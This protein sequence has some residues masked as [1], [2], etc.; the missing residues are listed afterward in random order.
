M[1]MPVRMTPLVLAT[2]G[3]LLPVRAADFTLAYQMDA[4]RGKVPRMETLRR[5]ADVV[6]SLGYRQL[7]MYFKGSFAYAGHEEVWKD[8]AHFTPAE[9]REL[10]DY[11]ASKGLELVP[12]QSTFSHLEPWLALPRYRPLAEAPEAGVTNR[13]KQV[14]TAPMALCPGDPRSMPLLEDIL[15]QLYPCFRTRL[16]NVGCDEMIELDDG[17]RRS[18]D[19]VARDGVGQVY[20]DF[21]MRLH[22]SVVRNGHVMMFWSDIVRDFPEQVARIP[23]DAIAL[24]WG[25]EADSPFERTTADLEKAP[26]RFYVCPGTSS[27]RSL[28]G[29]H[30]NMRANV[31]AAW[32]SGRRHGA[33][34]LLLTDWGDNGHCQPWIV[35]LPALVYAAAKAQGRTP[36]DAEIAEK[37]DGLCGAKVGAALI[38]LGNAYLRSNASRRKNVTEL[39][40]ACLDGRKYRPGRGVTKADLEASLAECRAAQKL[41]DLTGAPAWVR[42]DMAVVDLLVDVLACRIAG[43]H[44]G[45]TERFAGR[46]RELWNRQYKAEGAEASLANICGN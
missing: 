14:T 10:D 8:V 25:Y 35:S 42:D 19:A 34:G 17:G 33:S 5:M 12:Y 41:I 29:R 44:D 45:L 11:C 22:D 6:S 15:G 7:Q 21:V 26:C 9:A 20:F 24:D 46:Y 37:V 2:V 31:D 1:V 13:W 38:R 39:F 30:A 40:L 18:R 3:F 28:F 23:S 4:A 16:V 43:R 27:W 36:T 32:E